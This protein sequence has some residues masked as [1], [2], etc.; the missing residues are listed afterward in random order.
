[1]AVKSIFG[2]LAGLP[3]KQDFRYISNSI[4]AEKNNH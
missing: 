3:K 2:L 4:F 1:M